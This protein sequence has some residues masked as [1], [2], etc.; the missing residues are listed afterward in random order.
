MNKKIQG[1]TLLEG[2]LAITIAGLILSLGIRQ[3]YQFKFSRDAFALKYSVDL[4][5]QG[6]RNYY[7]ANCAESEDTDMTVHTLAPSRSPSNPYPLNITSTLSSYLDPKWKAASILIDR[8]FGYNG[9]E[10]QFNNFKPST[11]S[12]ANFCYYFPNTS[13]TSPVCSSLSN[14]SVNVSL[15]VAQVVVKISDPKMTLALKG[16]TN[17]DCALTDYQAHTI[18]DCSSGVTSGTPAYLVWQHLPTF[19]SPAMSSGL[20]RSSYTVKQFNLQYTNDPYW[21]LMSGETSN[22]LCGG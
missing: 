20:W 18:V 5:F 11:V 13:Q 3:Y 1:V 16:L 4:L 6:M 9:F 19:A 2:M 21:A 10:A 15:W 7:Y 22:Y 14:P 8:S 17:A 12:N